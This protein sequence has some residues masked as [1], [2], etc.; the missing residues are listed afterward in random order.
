MRGPTE[1][2]I[3]SHGRSAYQLEPGYIYLSRVP[4]VVKTVL[5]SCVAVCLWDRKLS[6]GGMN[7]FQ[8]PHTS[9]Q[10]EATARYGNV[11]ISTLVRMMEESG[12]RRRDL[13]A[14]IYGGGRPEELRGRDMGAENV[15]FARRLLSRK[16]IKVVSEDVG[17]TLGRKIIFDT[18]SGRVAVLKVDSIRQSDWYN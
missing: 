12:S 7:H 10:S 15:E 14:Q 3:D 1:N 11:A 4:S 8:Y 6:F 13:V 5:G 17:G 18:A 2:R 9:R 16:G